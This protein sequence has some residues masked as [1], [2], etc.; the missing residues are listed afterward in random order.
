MT[1]VQSS[2]LCATCHTLFTHALDAD[3]EVVGEL[4]EQVP[5]LEWKHSAYCRSPQLPVLPHA[6]GRGRDADLERPRVCR[7]RSVSRHVFRGGNF[8]MPQDPQ[9]SPRRSSAVKALPQELQTTAGAKCR[10]P[11]RLRPRTVIAREHRD[12]E[13]ARSRPRS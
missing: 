6:G 13:A 10:T 11:A 12:F 5:Y 2:E 9:R 3:G 8:F 1:H 7:A 4:P